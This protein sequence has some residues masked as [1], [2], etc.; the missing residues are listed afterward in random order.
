M[1][2]V[3]GVVREEF[4]Q[5]VAIQNGGY[6]IPPYVLMPPRTQ[7]LEDLCVFLR[8]LDGRSR[9]TA[10]KTE[11]LDGREAENEKYQEGFSGNNTHHEKNTPE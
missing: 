3:D 7:H 4:A 5:K 11:V 8:Q 9:T 1:S 6:A 10:T 2:K